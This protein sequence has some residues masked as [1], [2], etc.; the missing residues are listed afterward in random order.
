MLIEIPAALRRC[1]FLI[2]VFGKNMKELIKKLFKQHMIRY[3]FFGGCTTLVN[4]VSFA[5]LRYAGVPLNPANFVS[6]VLAIL[7]AYIVNSK[8]VFE[9]KY[10]TLKEHIFPFAK[11]IG[12]RLLTMVIELFGV[13]FFVERAGLPDLGGKILTNIIVLILNYIFSRF[14]V[15]SSRNKGKNNES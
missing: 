4:L 10:E 9:K 5:L 13:P 8:Y 14:F 6:I 11:F 3:V 12:A 2:F 15:F 7:F 1:G